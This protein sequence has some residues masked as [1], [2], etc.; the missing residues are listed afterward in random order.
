MMGF[1]DIYEKYCKTHP[2][3]ENN[4]ATDAIDNIKTSWKKHNEYND[5]GW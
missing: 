2:N 5:F 3:F 1:V 4:M